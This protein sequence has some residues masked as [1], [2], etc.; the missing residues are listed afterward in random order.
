MS[1]PANPPIPIGISQCLLGSHVRFNGSHKRS[2]LCTDVLAE[3]FE[4][5]PFCPEVAIG[6]GT[7]R[8]PIRLV[9]A[10]AAPKVLGSKDLQ[11]D[12]TAP[13]KRYGQ[14]ISSDRKDLCGFILMQKSPSCGME[15]VKVYLENGNPAAGTG[16]GVFA[17]ELMAGN[18]LLPIEEEGRL[19]D[20]VIRENF[21]TRVIAYA[22]WKNLASEEISTK[23][24]LDFHTRHK[25]LLLA[26]HP[27][28]YRA[29]GALLSN[30]KQADLTELADRYASLLMA[31]LR[32][33][34]SRGSHGNV[35]EHLA[36]HFKRALCKA[37]RSELRT[38]IG[39][40]RSGMIPLIVPITLLKHH[41]LNHPD[42]FLLRQV[43]LQPYPAE[44]SLR[45]A[46]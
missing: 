8:D 11:L 1:M 9:G 16:T 14:Q 40:Y 36:G 13:L 4:L 32:T 23:G 24:L 31:A 15:R 44:L 46:I 19:H 26:H 45:N 34:A 6:L 35:L 33:R 39:Q 7:P 17:A 3:H 29:M 27:A 5:I 37:E 42:P 21:V 28:H 22:D 38:L 2:S 12:V 41:L 30:L 10:P 18:P 25:Y 20:P 43:Y